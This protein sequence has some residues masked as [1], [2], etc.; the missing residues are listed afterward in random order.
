MQKKLF[1]IQGQEIPELL[2]PHQPRI[3]MMK[4]ENNNKIKYKTVKE[5]KKCERAKKIKMDKR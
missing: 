5:T 4:K 3:S 1:E 2:Q